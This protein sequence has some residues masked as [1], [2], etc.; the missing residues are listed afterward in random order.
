[1]IR[2]DSRKRREDRARERTEKF[3]LKYVPRQPP[4][5]KEK[6]AGG[7]MSKVCPSARSLGKKKMAR[8][9]THPWMLQM[10]IET[11]HLSLYIHP[12]ADIDAGAVASADL[13]SGR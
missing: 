2:S 3:R 5:K 11:D 4:L 12:V 10:P 6:K 7:N 8:M 13:A 9:Q 1:M